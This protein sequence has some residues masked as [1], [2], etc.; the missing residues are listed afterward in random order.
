M[1]VVVQR[2]KKSS[3][4]VTD[5][6]VGSINHGLVLL[7]SFTAEDSSKEIDWMIN[8]ILHLRIFDDENKIMNKSVT[9][10]ILS[11][12]QFTLYANCNKG[13]RPSYQK[14][15]N[16]RDANTLY[17]EFNRKL[18][19]YIHVEEGIFGSDMLVNIENDGPVTIIL[20]KNK[21]VC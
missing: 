17:Q 6:V 11:I 18:K 13:C 12:S 4:T 16:G 1:K 20:E 3:V 8:K 10:Q 19:K 5:K 7:V 14:A 9:G 2:S 21:E 15:L